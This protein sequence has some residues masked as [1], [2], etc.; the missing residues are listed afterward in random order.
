MRKSKKIAISI[1]EII[2][3]LLFIAFGEITYKAFAVEQSL[4]TGMIGKDY[5]WETTEDSIIITNCYTNITAT[6]KDEV[7]Y[8]DANDSTVNTVEEFV[9]SKEIMSN[10]SESEYELF[11]NLLLGSKIMKLY[12]S[13]N[14][15]TV[16][17]SV[18]AC[19]M[20]S[21]VNF[22]NTVKCIDD[23]TFAYSSVE[24]VEFSNSLENI[25]EYAFGECG[26]LTDVV[27]PSSVNEIGKMAFFDCSNLKNVVI[28]S[29]NANIQ[30]F[31]F[32]Y[33]RDDSEKLKISDFMITGYSGS[34][35]EAYANE[36]GFIFIALDEPI[37]TTTVQ[38]TQATTASTTATTTT[39]SSDNSESTN[40]STTVTTTLSTTAITS[41]NPKTTMQNS[42]Q[43]S[44]T[45][46]VSNQTI[47][48]TQKVNS[49]YNGNANN[50]K[51]SSSSSPKTGDSFPI[52]SALTAI[53]I[54]T[55]ST[56]LFMKK[57]K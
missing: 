53:G 24:D 57:R 1:L 7:C 33:Y 11:S 54:S 6:I 34:T 29:K 44:T 18:I 37:S 23:Y 38:T 12:Y 13:D 45:G 20:I 25:G 46:I 3:M 43:N 21:K 19:D 32:G 47:T 22:G 9:V 14:I 16:R 28:Y 56:V 40:I 17:D 51:G 10:W 8:V 4:K 27:L 26:V 30:E 36:N 42:A 52:V 35:A 55:L 49:V 50:S 31:A 2:S 5:V 39:I 41:D 15:I 48:T